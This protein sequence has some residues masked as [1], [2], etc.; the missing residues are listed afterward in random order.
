[1][2]NKSQILRTI[3]HDDNDDDTDDD[4]DNGD[5]EENDDNNG[6]HDGGDIAAPGTGASC[7]KMNAKSPIPQRSRHVLIIAEK[8]QP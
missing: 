8:R 6:D 5:D 1:M 4:G 2:T 7:A 3:A